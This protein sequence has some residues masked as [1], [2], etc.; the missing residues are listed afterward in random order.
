LGED[1]FPAKW[2]AFIRERQIERRGRRFFCD[3]PLVMRHLE[4]QAEKVALIGALVRTRGLSVRLRTDRWEDFSTV[5]DYWTAG[6]NEPFATPILEAAFSHPEI[7]SIDIIQLL[8]PVPR[9]LLNTYPATDLQVNA[10]LP[11]CYWTALNFFHQDPAARMLDFRAVNS[12]LRQY[13]RRLEP[14]DRALGDIHLLIDP[15]TDQLI[16]SYV[17]IA[18]EIV[19]TKNGI[20][21]MAPW[22]LMRESDMLS[23]YEHRQLENRSYRLR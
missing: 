4:S 14:G 10:D 23:R 15:V 8:P 19:Y 13:Y 17:S 9:K 6:R 1:V 3:T 18:G 16:H 22:V 11:D 7:E 21:V 5:A 2:R 12:H 20:S